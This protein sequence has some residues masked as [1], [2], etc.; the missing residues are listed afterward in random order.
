VVAKHPKHAASQSLYIQ[1]LIETDGANVA[2]GQFQQALAAVPAENRSELVQALD[3]LAH[4]LADEGLYSAALAHLTLALRLEGDDAQ[5][6]EH[7]RLQSLE[8]NPGILPWLRNVYRLSPVPAGLD[9]ERR[10]R[11][12]EALAWADQG[13]WSPAAAAFD[14]LSA[15]GT[16]ES[17]RNL[18]LCRLWLG[19][20][21]GV[22]S[23][24]RRYTSWI[25][26]TPDTVDLEALCQ[27][28]DVPDE[29]DQVEI[30]QWIWPLRERAA[31]LRALETDPCVRQLG[32]ASLDPGD[33]AA[34]EMDRF[35]VLDRPMPDK[36]AVSGPSDVPRV[37]GTIFVGQ[38]IAFIQAPD[39]GRLDALGTWFRERA[40]GAIP[41]A[42]PRTKLIGRSPREALALNTDW[43][44]PDGLDVSEARRLARLERRRVLKEVFP[45]LPAPFLGGR[46]PLQA[47][48]DRKAELALRGALM[49]FE[50]SPSL[51]ENKSDV[52]ELRHELGLAPEPQIDPA[53]ATIASIHLTR[54]HLVPAAR[55]DDK[56][57]IEYYNRARRYHVQAALVPAARALLDRPHLLDREGMVSRQTIYSD[58]ALTSLA[59]GEKNEALAWVE[60]GRQADPP[61]ARA[62]N[63]SAWDLLDVRIRA[64]TEEPE[65][66][67][68]Q[69]AVVLERY[70]NQKEAG[71]VVLRTLLDLGLVQVVP[72]PDRPGEIFL[73]SRP[74]QAVLGKYGPR[75]TTSTG[76]LGVSAARSEIWTPGSESAGSRGTVWTPESGAAAQAPVE[77]KRLII[78]GR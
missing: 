72:S 71:S 52:A 54:L 22:V 5:P 7:P 56:R 40:G 31:L 41:P 17:D 2:A 21:K 77:S 16:A 51:E 68:P 39:D 46:T 3:H 42:H 6:T 10:Q 12:A 29:R 37:R 9:E 30:L 57:L 19:D 11:F 20:H 65:A 33:P 69:L 27:V 13:L 1:L 62:R 53:T 45:N 67:V 34:P 8:A 48:G 15:A 66:W 61:A 73:D 24:L 4:G 44:L 38:E 36:S 75:I 25:G 74:L 35:L 49:R 47:R 55:L 59:R 60:R 23:A 63:A 58:L 32:R 18:G 26:P 28:I 43:M 70:K 76:E 50:Y 64:E 78:P 14:M